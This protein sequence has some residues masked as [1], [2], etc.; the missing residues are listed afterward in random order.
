V[1][2]EVKILVLFP[3]MLLDNLVVLV[4]ELDGVQQQHQQQVLLLVLLVELMIA[5]LQQQDGE[6]PVELKLLTADKVVVA[7][8]AVL[9][10]LDHHL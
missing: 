7:A 2:E 8:P 6:I 4:V 1:E 3:L 5:L 10:I 9:V